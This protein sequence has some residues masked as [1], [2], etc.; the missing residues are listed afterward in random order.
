VFHASIWGAWRG[1]APT[2]LGGGTAPSPGSARDH[3]SRRPSEMLMLA[4]MNTYKQ[5][6]AVWG[7]M[8]DT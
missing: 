7:N 1:L 6:C 2:P 8:Y 4:N 5:S 3:S